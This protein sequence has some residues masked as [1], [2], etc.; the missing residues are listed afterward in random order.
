MVEVSTKTKKGQELLSRAICYR[1]FDLY[2]VYGSTSKKKRDAWGECYRKYLAE[3][4]VDFRICS[5]N[6]WSF[7]V[8]WRV[9]DGWRMETRTH[10]Y[11]IIEED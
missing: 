5:Y 2:D 10:S 6:G 4:G 9:S 8:S 3:Q 1:G 11:H 7:S